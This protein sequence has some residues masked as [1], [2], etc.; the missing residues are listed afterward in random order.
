MKKNLS[1]LQLS[2]NDLKDVKAGAE[3]TDPCGCYFVFSGGAN[4]D[5]N[6]NANVSQGLH[7][8][9]CSCGT[10]SWIEYPSGAVV[11]CSNYHSTG[12]SGAAA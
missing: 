5:D 12:M 9:P 2:R 11:V 8:C 3:A 7:S 1:L 6:H 4:M 10:T